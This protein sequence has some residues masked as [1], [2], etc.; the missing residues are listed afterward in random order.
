MFGWLDEAVQATPLPAAKPT[1]T[2][3]E[4]VTS[5]PEVPKFNTLRFRVSVP[6]VAAAAPDCVMPAVFP[7]IVKF[8]LRAWELGLALT[9][10]D[11]IVPATDTEAQAT[12]ELAADAG[13]STG[14]AVTVMLPAPPAA[15]TLKLDGF[16]L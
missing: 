3:C 10:Q 11:A 16:R 15:P 13:Q 12:P 4:L 7:P 1:T 9:D 6:G 8:P 5:D 2:D 14:L